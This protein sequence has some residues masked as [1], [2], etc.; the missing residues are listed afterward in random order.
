MA[1]QKVYSIQING[2]TESVKAVDALNESLKNLESRIKA[3]E[4]KSVKVGAS[5]SGGGSKSSSTSSLSEEEKL[6]KQIA[7]LEEK[8]IAH[9][10]QIYQNYLA[11]K[12]V[13]SETEKDQKQIAASERLAAKSYS[14]TIAGMKQELADI[15]AVMQTVDVGDSGQMKQMIDR[16]KELNDKLKEIEQSYGQFSRNVGNYSSAFD[17]F[18]KLKVN[19]A[20]V[21]QEFDSAKQAAKTLATELATLQAKKDQGII[22]TEEETKRFKELPTIVAQI[23]SSIQDAGKPMD[24]LMDS[25]Q[26]FVAIAQAGKGFSAFFGLDND[27][28]ERSIQKLVALQNAMQGLQKIQEQMQSMEGIGKVFSNGSKSIDNFVAKITKAKIGVDGLEKS[29]KLGTTAVNLFSKALKGLASLGVIAAITALIA[30]LEEGFEWIKDWVKGD[31]DLVSAEDALTAAIEQQ[32]KVLNDNVDLIQKK[33]DA[34]EISKEQARIETEEAYAKALAETNKRLLEREDAYRNVGI[35]QPGKTDLYLG[36]AI[37]D[38][39]VTSIGG[40]EEGI[41]GIE[42]FNKRWDLLSTAVANGTDALNKWNYTA[43]NAKDDFVHMS[44][45]AGGDLLNAFNKLADGTREGTKALVE[46]INHMDEL[47]GG[48]YSQAIKIGIDK[49]YLDEQF[50]MAW[51]QYEKL[52]ND[53][54]RDPILVNLEIVAD[55]N[56]FL[57]SLDPNGALKERIANWK[58]TLEDNIKDGGKNLSATEI[59]T[60]NKAIAAGEKKLK[61]GEAKHN[62]TLTKAYNS[63]KKLITDAERELANLRIS[64]M[65]EGLNKTLTQLEENRRQELAK[66]KTNG[67]MVEELS[68]EIN[69][70]YDNEIIDAKK[71][72]SD[73]VLQVYSNMWDNIYSLTM[74]NARMTADA[75]ITELENNIEKVQN[76]ADKAL[77]KKYSDYSININ[78]ISK[79]AQKTTGIIPNLSDKYGDTPKLKQQVHE[80]IGLLEEIDLAEKYYAKASFETGG[81]YA[82]QYKKIIDAK[83][84]KLQEW[85]EENKLTEEKLR[86]SSEYETLMAR[87]FTT[88]LAKQYEIR[89]A[90]RNLY[91][92]K[93]EKAAK[94]NA[95]AILK[96]EKYL[97]DKETEFEKKR[98]ESA[99]V[100]REKE[101][102]AQE[103]T[104]INGIVSDELRKRLGIEGTY[105]KDKLAIQKKY[106]DLRKK[107]EEEF[108]NQLA[109]IDK[110]HKAEAER[111]ELNHQNEIKNIVANAHNNRI[112]EYRDFISRLQKIQASTPITDD[113]GWGVVRTS[114]TRRQYRDALEGYKKLSTDIIQEKN[115]LQ[116]SLDKNEIS[117]DDFQQAQRELNLLQESVSEATN[118]ILKNLKFFLIPGVDNTFGQLMQS[119]NTYIQAGLQAVQTVMQAL[120]DYQDYQF[121]KEQEMLD[122][123][124]EMLE[125]KL[126]KQQEIVEEHKN[127]IESIEDELATS[128]GDRRQHLIDQL[129]AEMEAQRRAQ[130]EEENIQKKKDANEKKQ[131]ALEK[132]RK[133]AEY[134]RN[135]LSILVSTAMATANG[136]ATKPFVPVGIAMG[137][138]ATTLG[139]VQYAL[140]AK[141]KPYAKGGQLDGGQVVGNRHRDGGVKVLGGRAEIEGG[142]FITNRISTQMNAPLLEFINSK[143]KKIDVSD[144]MEFYSSGSVKRSIAKVKTKFE[145]GGYLPTL[146][147]ALDVRDQLQNVIINQDNRPIYVSVVDINNKQEDVRRV[148]TLAGL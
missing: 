73:E 131:E 35:Q 115:K 96:T 30:L 108:K 40:F 142:E 121:E 57:K 58:K 101:Y 128:R 78:N 107:S 11:A 125:E 71:K 38:T 143:K 69:I 86:A 51:G 13:L 23:K 148:Q 43:D 100:A 99:F 14:N 2:L 53:I 93:T 39:G 103:T 24:A 119:I 112:Q 64:N 10:K 124:N 56:S 127:N 92:L 25:M 126:D 60:L 135:L 46:Y 7:Q 91:Y 70:K 22:L 21:V 146:P 17:G 34:G 59:D 95:D 147:N 75:E 3:L 104:E 54:Y 117:F 134:K 62:A 122:R 144:L 116:E 16:A 102:N 110:T 1:A 44:K 72:W 42:D 9:S 8:R 98:A 81:E 27:E 87:N 133:Q 88:S 85:L 74:Q 33:L 129:N 68:K 65:K 29:T 141:A 52:K 111:L 123:E 137:A 145:D 114:E 12:D 132:K 94:D 37:G 109:A 105:E 82:E 4:G 118:E 50:K 45:L 63:R 18:E 67:V 36:N 80:Y 89:M 106:E 140:A 76:A 55:A 113:A 84:E 48:R 130:K 31:A 20:G 15:K 97:L 49:G 83:K 19:V 32:N 6:E 139:M 138:L 120:A 77:D 61:E 136:L 90:D 5:S 79:K 28:I 66:V 47:T 41:K 26:S